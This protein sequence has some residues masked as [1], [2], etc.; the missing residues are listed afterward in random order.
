[1]QEGASK[2][3]SKGKKETGKRYLKK[4]KLE[5]TDMENP[6]Q[7]QVKDPEALYVF[8][9]DLQDTSVPKIIGVYLD[10]NHMSVANEVLGLGIKPSELGV[11]VLFGFATVFRAPKFII[12]TN[13]PSVDATPDESDRKLIRRLQAQSHIMKKQFVDYV[14]VA[15]KTYWSMNVLDGTACHCG[16]QEYIPEG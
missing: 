13:H 12:I 2:D 1:M 4:F 7:G 3:E 15:G 14:I 6:I 16:Q 5:Q 9:R 11:D 8:M 10:E